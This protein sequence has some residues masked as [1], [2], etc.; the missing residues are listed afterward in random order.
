MIDSL[1]VLYKFP[2][3]IF[4]QMIQCVS[5]WHKFPQWCLLH[6]GKEWLVCFLSLDVSAVVFTPEAN[7]RSVALLG[8]ESEVSHWKRKDWSTMSS[9]WS[10]LITR[11]DGCK[12]WRYTTGV[13]ISDDDI[14]EI[15][16]I[17]CCCVNR[18]LVLGLSL[19][20]VGLMDPELKL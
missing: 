2:Q 1:V 4:Y 13:Y 12:L 17:T 19:T 16:K 7:R 20:L 9:K 11:P 10:F 3:I 5:L 15:N 14:W 18:K 8:L 6:T